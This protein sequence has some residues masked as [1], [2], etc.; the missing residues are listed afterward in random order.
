MPIFVSTNRRSERM[1][2]GFDGLLMWPEAVLSERPV[3]TARGTWAA[4]G[5]TSIVFT[6]SDVAWREIELPR[7]LW[8]RELLA[9]DVDSTEDLVSF[10]ND[11]G[12]LVLDGVA[13]GVDRLS[14]RDLVRDLRV[15]RNIARVLLVV[16]G[17]SPEHKTVDLED[18]GT[19]LEDR[20]ERGAPDMGRVRWAVHAINRN[21]AVMAPR[22]AVSPQ[23]LVNRDITLASALAVQM[24]NFAVTRPHVSICAWCGSPFILQRGRSQ[25]GGHRTDEIV[26]YCS[27]EHSKAAARKRYR[28]RKRNGKAKQE[29]GESDG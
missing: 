5:D 12:A 4:D 1:A 10:V 6:E 15:A 20:I 16:V 7:E 24:F 18:D 11:Y 28:D 14:V 3:M 17:D 13:S 8:M 19:S 22:L 9:L 26:K 23:N 2:K 29:G 21:L 27:Y 25:Y